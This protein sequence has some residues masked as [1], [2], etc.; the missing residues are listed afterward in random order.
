MSVST[1]TRYKLEVWAANSIIIFALFWS[2]AFVVLALLETN[3]LHSGCR[4]TA[5]AVE[6]AR[7]H[8]CVT[9]LTSCVVIA[10]TSERLVV[11][12]TTAVKCLKHCALSGG[13]E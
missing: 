9:D 4:A 2:Y 3:K 10:S 12:E 11:C 5:E 13:E 6:S 7:V 8:R 1:G